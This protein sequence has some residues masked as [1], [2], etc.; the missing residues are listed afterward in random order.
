MNSVTCGLQEGGPRG[1]AEVWC[2]WNHSLEPAMCPHPPLLGAAAANVV[3]VVKV[4]S[5]S[6]RKR[7]TWS[8]DQWS[9]GWRRRRWKRQERACLQAASQ[10]SSRL[11]Q[12]TMAA[13]GLLGMQDSQP[14]QCWCGQKAAELSLEGGWM[15][16]G[17]VGWWKDSC[18]RSLSWAEGLAGALAA[19]GLSS[20]NAGEGVHQG[21]GGQMCSS[22][23][24]C[25]HQRPW[26][27][28]QQSCT[29]VCGLL[30][31]HLTCSHSEHGV[32]GLQP[33]HVNLRG[34]QAVTEKGFIVSVRKVPL[35]RTVTTPEQCPEGTL[36]MQLGS[37]PRNC[38]Q[39]QQ[40]LLETWEKPQPFINW[41]I[42]TYWSKTVLP[43]EGWN[44]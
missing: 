9:G 10:L 23:E 29:E 43:W 14:L 15:G 25:R 44:T 32:E 18:P 42:Y 3:V 5:L 33:W 38:C 21:F 30:E 20:F 8:R 35:Q 11:L 19:W 2:G 39:C 24:T 17:L 27:V 37:E 28:L 26:D 6:F 40:L 31:E 1:A 34:T 36:H 4:A 41:G 22:G 13:E 7:D 16:Q 12:L